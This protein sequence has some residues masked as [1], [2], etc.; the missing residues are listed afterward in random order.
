MLQ[1]LFYILCIVTCLIIGAPIG[2]KLIRN[3]DESLLQQYLLLGGAEI[4]I[5][6]FWGGN[7]GIPVKYTMLVLVVVNAFFVI[8]WRKAIF[9]SLN[10]KR[11][12]AFLF[13]CVL[14]GLLSMAPIL[15]YNACSPYVDGYTY[16]CIGD[17]LKD[18]G[19]SH[20]VTLDQFHPWLTQIGLYKHY[21]FRIGVQYL[22]AF[23]C[24]LFSLKYSI[25]VYAPVSALGVFLFGC[26]VCTVVYRTAN[27]N[28]SY[29]A[30]V[31]SVFNAPI[32]MWIAIFGFLPQ[33]F[34]MV[35][36]IASIYGFEIIVKKEEIS[37]KEY[38][39]GTIYV[40]SMSICYSEIV[41]F[42]VLSVIA[43]LIYKEFIE[44]SLVSDI[45]K[46]IIWA[47]MTIITLNKYFIDMIP[48]LLLQFGAAVGW[49]T[50]YDLM[51]YIGMIF[52]TVPV[53]YSFLDT[54]GNL[55][56][57]YVLGI[58]TILAV[59]LLGF[60]INRSELKNKKKVLS[61]C[62]VS[63][64]PF[65]IMLIYFRFFSYDIFLDKIGNNWSIFKMVQYFY[66]IPCIFLFGFYADAF[67][68]IILKNL[69]CALI[70]CST[71]V[72]TI[73]YSKTAVSSMLEFTGNSVNPLEEYVSLAEKYK[74]E[75]KI[76]NLVDIP[77]EHRK[78][79]T[80]FMRD[81]KLASDWSSDGYFSFYGNI[82]DPA[83]DYNGITLSYDSS[84][85]NE[86]AGIIEVEPKYVEVN[87][88]NGVGVYEKDEVHC[89]TWN[90]VV[91]DYNLVNYSRGDKA[92]LTCGFAS[93]ATSEAKVSVFVN[94]QLADEVIIMPGQVIYY[95]SDLNF[96]GKQGMKV[97]F[98]YT[99][100]TMKPTASDSREL[101][102]RVLDF[103]IDV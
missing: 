72:N 91:S 71:T 68:N 42:W 65:L 25:F 49:K 15:I 41:P 92:T 57:R 36:M 97:E 21:G 46:I 99:G 38:V 96:S 98:I 88:G 35:F 101:S 78:L 16:I 14:A 81:N 80:Y 51:S 12:I 69:L 74:N 10:D 13:F 63:S 60:G 26:A 24:S 50:N 27:F 40:A 30:V 73:N 93:A 43:L 56:R 67:R 47:L 45:K 54:S 61:S 6:C 76:I 32:L 1:I 75:D 17:Y 29:I 18:H 28:H 55:F 94:G 87:P 83:C 4:I 79:L 86:I 70:I 19:Y 31:V 62:L 33:L 39:L 9:N 48:A 8:L 85:E 102:L 20:D 34:G 64:I 82:K 100:E 52:N 90:D 2:T 58:Y 44:Q 77:L 103:R 3:D 5:V 22:L 66:V 23:F 37:L 7:I 95:E 11:K 53:G 84:S 89:W 59:V